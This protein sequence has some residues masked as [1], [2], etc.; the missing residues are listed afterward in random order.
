MYD[1]KRGGKPERKSAAE[2][3]QEMAEQE[4]EDVVLRDLERKKNPLERR[5][6]SVH[7]KDDVVISD[8]SESPV[9]PST[10]TTGTTNISNTPTSDDDEWIEL[11]RR[12]RIA[13]PRPSGVA[14]STSSMRRRPILRRFH[15]QVNPDDVR[16]TL[17]AALRRSNYYQIPG[18]IHSVEHDYD[19][20][21][22]I[23]QLLSPTES[24]RSST[25]RERSQ[26]V[27]K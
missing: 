1:K 18:S 27:T 2:I 20:P 7:F 5:D 14:P 12:T 23:T 25:M 6:T 8:D 17:A 16:S 26:S 13:L 19:E 24:R 10:P 22:T 21:D 11:V 4:A 3:K 15:S 9:T